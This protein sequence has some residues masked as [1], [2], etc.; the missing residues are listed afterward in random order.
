LALV[1]PTFGIEALSLFEV[2]DRFRQVANFVEM[3]AQAELFS[4]END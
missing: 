4:G 2:R 1:I 3:L